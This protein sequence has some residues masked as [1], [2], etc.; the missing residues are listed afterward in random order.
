MTRSHLAAALMAL[1]I[2]AIIMSL[3]EADQKRR[4]ERLTTAETKY[5]ATYEGKSRDGEGGGIWTLPD[6]RTLTCRISGD[7]DDPTLACG[8]EGEEPKVASK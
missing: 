2:L 6:G 5:D 1:G 4:V 8:S 3:A 7:V